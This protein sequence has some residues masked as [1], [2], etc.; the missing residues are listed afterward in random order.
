MG[1]SARVRL[2]AGFVLR[3]DRWVGGLTP[4]CLG[5]YW[6]VF[7]L[8]PNT[9]QPALPVLLSRVLLRFSLLQTPFLLSWVTAGATSFPEPCFFVFN[10]CSPLF[11]DVAS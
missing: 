9:T 4:C 8:D 1:Q 7:P 2:S 6:N 3:V 11:C 5:R 10:N